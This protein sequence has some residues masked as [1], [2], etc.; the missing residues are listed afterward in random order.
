MREQMIKVKELL[1]SILEGF[2]ISVL[3]ISFLTAVVVVEDDAFIAFNLPVLILTS[4]LALLIYKNKISLKRVENWFLAFVGNRKVLEEVGKGSYKD[5][6]INVMIASLI[7]II[8]GVPF[9]LHLIAGKTIFSCISFTSFP[10]IAKSELKLFG[11]FFI[12]SILLYFSAVFFGKKESF[13]IATQKYSYIFSAFISLISFVGMCLLIYYYYN[14][15]TAFVLL[16]SSYT[17]QVVYIASISRTIGGIILGWLFGI[18]IYIYTFFLTL[19]RVHR[20]EVPSA[21]LSAIVLTMLYSFAYTYIILKYLFGITLIPLFIV[22][23]ATLLRKVFVEV[24]RSTV[25]GAHLFEI[26]VIPF[27][28]IPSQYEHRTSYPR[29]GLDFFHC[30]DGRK[31]RTIV[32]SA[33]DSR[34]LKSRAL[35]NLIAFADRL[36]NKTFFS[37]FALSFMGMVIIALLLD[38]FFLGH[39]LES[40]FVKFTLEFLLV[41]IFGEIL[42]RIIIGEV[43]TEIKLGGEEK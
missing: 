31:H 16:T 43:Q 6:V 18:P 19:V 42:D 3:I 1:K 24:G 13:K 37:T 15:Y 11:T 21:I 9:P 22:L 34:V 30:K 41:L 35:V 20:L 17:T 40:K 28:G 23:I 2:A 5:A 12:F 38:Y 8:L 39:L 4:I 27:L 7:A 29:L 36:R 32:T 14:N 33:S 25:G 10:T 26:L